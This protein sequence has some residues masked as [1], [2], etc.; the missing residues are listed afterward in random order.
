MDA[1][2]FVKDKVG[3]DLAV[4]ATI[5]LL[6]V[7]VH[8]LSPSTLPSLFAV[9]GGMNVLSVS[10]TNYLSQ[11]P[12]VNGPSFL[13]TFLAGGS[14]YIQATI[15]PG[16]VSA[17]VN[18]NTKSFSIAL[19]MKNSQCAF[20]M[21]ID[22]N[23]GINKITI[24][25]MSD[26]MYPDIFDTLTTLHSECYGKDGQFAYQYIG[27][28]LLT[29]TG[30]YD[31]ACYIETNSGHHPGI[32]Q[33]ID[34][35]WDADITMQFDG[36][37]PITGQF[38]EQKQSGYIGSS[39]EV[40]VAQL[41]QLFNS[42]MCSTPQATPIFNGENIARFVLPY[43][44]SRYTSAYS[45]Y[46]AQL[47]NCF[48][49]YQQCDL[50]A[51]AQRV[52][53][54][55]GAYEQ[56]S[57]TNINLGVVEN[58][59]LIVDFPSYEI[60][61]NSLF[62]MRVR[63]DKIQVVVPEVKPIISSAVFNSVTEGEW[64][65][66]TAYIGNSGQTGRVGIGV[67]CQLGTPQTIDPVYVPAGQSIVVQVPITLTGIS[68]DTTDQCQ[69]RAY[70][71]DN[72]NNFDLKQVPCR[73]MNREE[74]NSMP[75][76]C[77]EDGNIY[78]CN[79][80]GYDA[81]YNIK[82]VDC[83]YGCTNTNPPTCKQNPTEC[84]LV[85][86]APCLDNEVCSAALLGLGKPVCSKLY[87]AEGE[88]AKNHACIAAFGDTDLPLAWI[89]LAG[90]F[91]FGVGYQYYEGS[92]DKERKNNAILI[93]LAGMFIP[94]M[95]QYA[96][97]P[98]P[99]LD[100]HAYNAAKSIVPQAWVPSATTSILVLGA[101]G[102][103]IMGLNTLNAGLVVVGFIVGGVGGYF[104]RDILLA[105]QPYAAVIG[106]FVGTY[107]AL[108]LLGNVQDEKL[109][110]VLAAALGILAAL[111]IYVSFFIGVIVVAA[112]LIVK[113]SIIDKFDFVELAAK[114]GKK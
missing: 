35:L 56:L 7:S 64:G 33:N 10:Q 9:G 59:R 31:T 4:F 114:I 66:I 42:H 43:E 60:A 44:F 87:C 45:T 82:I 11:D 94:V 71:V 111:L 102:A 26:V 13:I 69:L 90:L 108:G 91:F 32:F 112:Y 65:Y 38:S 107:F 6:L 49:D 40:Y 5:V 73:W 53:D 19:D 84:N 104:L 83:Q 1:I 54:V 75:T 110:Y 34:F 92:P 103:I 68:Q 48:T 106:G 14:Q 20:P 16:E 23:T 96:N 8:I 79:M 46:Q 74:C 15:L 12:T 99:P 93:A 55:N 47:N 78:A 97:L 63:A 95:L 81:V 25:E 61:P 76:I 62:S 100:D 27:P 88:V 89:L 24:E 22:F 37:Q 86:N 57:Q 70:S 3:L 113:F 77:K 50:G 101:I 30:Y 41:G 29:P 98:L 2:R 105:V 67:S 28:G 52:T 85:T 21:S 18:E 36:E 39:N 80:V 51:L 72:P 58:N 17:G 109:R